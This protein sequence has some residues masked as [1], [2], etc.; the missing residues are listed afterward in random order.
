MSTNTKDE[1]M[2]WVL[3]FV[4]IS[5]L[6]AGCNPPP[7]TQPP[8]TPCP[9]WGCGPGQ[10]FGPTTTPT[11]IP[12]AI[13]PTS[14]STPTLPSTSTPMPPTDERGILT[15][16]YR[17][18]AY[19]NSTARQYL[20]TGLDIKQGENLIMEATGTACFGPESGHCNG[21]NG[22]PDFDDTDLVGKIDGSEMFHIGSSFQKTV[23]NEGGRLY[24]GFSD[25]DYENNSGFFDVTVTIENTL[26]KTCNP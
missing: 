1:I 19:E 3:A 21:P 4:L 20:D 6:L 15:C 24:L 5:L 14:T 7:V 17:V 8:L 13:P 22:H 16:T 18:S 9:W 11:P 12:T 23:S 10:I 25:T 26:T 2:R